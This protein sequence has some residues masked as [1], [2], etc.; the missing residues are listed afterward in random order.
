MTSSARG[1]PKRQAGCGARL[2]SQARILDQTLRKMVTRMIGLRH[3]SD[4][5]WAT[6]SQNSSTWTSQVIDSHCRPW[7]VLWSQLLWG[8]A[9]HLRRHMELPCAG[10]QL[11]QGSEWLMHRREPW[12]SGRNGL[13]GGRTDTRAFPGRPW[14]WKNFCY[15]TIF[16][17][18][19]MADKKFAYNQASRMCRLH[20][21]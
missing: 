13:G 5:S 4:E 12:S 19:D 8:W 18:Q 9:S 15:D 11:V 6:F 21:L 1:G 14:R 3:R 16:C 10:L 17:N 2:R 7:S 20:G